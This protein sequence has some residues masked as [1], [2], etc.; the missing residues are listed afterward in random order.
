MLKV[1][2]FFEVSRVFHFCIV[3]KSLILGSLIVWLSLIGN[4][5][6]PLPRIRVKKKEKN[7]VKVIK[8]NFV[9]VNLLRL[10]ERTTE[11]QEWVVKKTFGECKLAS[12]KKCISELHTLLDW[13]KEEYLI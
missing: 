10:L 2:K 11:E 7:P 1:T 9:G 12:V 8:D 4:N 5:F 13:A 3:L 6:T